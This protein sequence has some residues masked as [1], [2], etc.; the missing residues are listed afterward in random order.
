MQSENFFSGTDPIIGAYTVTL[1]GN[2]PITGT[3]VT[4]SGQPI[5]SGYVKMGLQIYPAI[6]GQYII[7]AC[8]GDNFIKGFE[9]TFPDSTTASDLIT[10]QVTS[11]GVDVSDL[12]CETR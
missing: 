9:T 1:T 11:L 4:C 6:Q 8:L 10:V 12:S 3:V 2:Y 5:I 7:Y